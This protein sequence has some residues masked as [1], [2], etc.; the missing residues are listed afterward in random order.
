MQTSF[1]PAEPTPTVDP[2]APLA[3][4]LRPQTLDEIVGQEHLLG[5]GRALRQAIEQGRIGSLVLWGPPGTGKTSLAQVI[6]RR[7]GARSVSLSATSAGLADLRQAL[8]EA[9]RLRRQGQRLVLVVD[10]VHR[11]SRAQQDALLPAVEEGLVTLIGLTS[12]NPF[13]GL[14][15]AL[16]SRLR[17]FRLEPLSRAALAQVLERALRTPERGL[18][19]L[20]VQIEPAARD[21]LLDTA[22]GDARVLLNT[23]EAAVTL[24]QQP[25]GQVRIDRA[26]V[27]E[28]LQRRPVRYD[29]AGDDHYQTISAF[30]KSVRG[31]DPDAAVFWLAKMLAAGEDPRFIAR[32]LAILAAEDIGLADP[33]ALLIAEA[34][35][36]AVSE[37]GMPESGL[38]LAE[39][40]LYLATAPKSNRAARALWAAQQAI[41]QGAPLEVPRH[42]R[43]ASFHGAAALGYGAGYEYS[44]DFAADDPRRYRQRYLPEGVDGPFYE[45]GDQGYE[46][47]VARRLDVWRALRAAAG[48]TEPTIPGGENDGADSAG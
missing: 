11:W 15:P 27:Q 13:F 24:G 36:R 47:T 46:A 5:P 41:E 4:R 7:L 18:G 34:A 28:A 10:E 43:P 37:I 29:R 16:R 22:G 9:R 45:P 48:S 21:L 40:T 31:S 14:I 23:L 1:W 6:V 2:T 44:H 38:I 12:E 30:I 20:A 33:Q 42:L 35:L 19:H 39:A 8:E 26:V 25:D 3:A 32:R 17:V